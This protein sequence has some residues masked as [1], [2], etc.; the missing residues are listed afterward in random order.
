MA[1]GYIG[2]IKIFGGSFAPAGWAFC[3]GSLLETGNYEVLF[4]LLKNTYGGD[5]VNNF[6]LP[7][8]R[9]RVPIHAG[10]GNGLSART[11]GETGGAE[12]VSLTTAQLP[13]HSHVPR[14]NDGKGEADTPA[15]NFWAA[16]SKIAQFVA[17]DLANTT[18]NSGAV[19]ANGADESHENMLPFLP[20]NFIICLDGDF[21]ESD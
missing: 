4:A 2:E 7:D 10:Q 13:S 15:G 18:M 19:Q 16:S 1:D 20:L 14:V 21:P 5:G 11:L 3:D 9:G 8:L 6:A 12:T 17:A